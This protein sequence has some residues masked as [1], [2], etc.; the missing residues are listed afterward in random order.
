MVVSPSSL[1]AASLA[2]HHDHRL[3]MA[4]GLLSRGLP[5]LVVQNPEVVSKSWP[6]FFDAIKT[7]YF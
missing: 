6:G 7:F 4:V 3:A 5:G 2:T 1:S